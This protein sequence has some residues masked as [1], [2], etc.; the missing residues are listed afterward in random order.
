MSE[1]GRRYNNNGSDNVGAAAEMAAT[2]E[3]DGDDSSKISVAR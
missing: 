2:V 3:G 1:I